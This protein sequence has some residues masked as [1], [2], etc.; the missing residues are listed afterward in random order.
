MSGLRPPG[1]LSLE[2]NLAKNYAD[3][4]REFNVY[5]IATQ[6]TEKPE[7]VRCA[8]FLH[9]A[10]PQ[11]QAIHQT[12]TFTRDEVNKIEPLKQKFKEYCEPKRNITVIRYLFNT[13]NQHT[14]EPFAKFV[15]DLKRLAK[16]CEFDALEES[17]MKDRIVCGI[18]DSALREKLLQIDNLTFKQCLDMCTVAEASAEHIKQLAPQDD[19]G[20]NNEAVDAVG[21]QARGR[22]Q[23][24]GRG[25]VGSRNSRERR[26]RDWRGHRGDEDR[27]A[28]N[29]KYCT[30]RHAV[31]NRCP[32]EF[33]TCNSC[34]RE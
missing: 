16:D 34:G 10:G 2:G 18:R 17:L 9:V 11:A 21:T 13:R 6:L 31:D 22:P 5:E 3:W 30:Y 14:G 33:Q 15:T 19:A 7:I 23:Q 25:D 1:P 29:C 20:K 32:A 12:L 4:I 24:R 27:R 26:Q 8:T 28:P